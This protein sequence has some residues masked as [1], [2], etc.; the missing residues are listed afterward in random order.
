MLKARRLVAEQVAEQLYAAEAA[1]DAAI[2][3]TATLTGMMPA[4]RAEAG[5]SA[6][7][8]QEA[9]VEASETTAMLVRARS[10]ICA[11]H[12]ALTLAQKQMG[13]GAVNFGGLIIKPAASGEARH[14]AAVT[15][16]EQAA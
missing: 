7:I 10:S 15:S 9:I 5:L 12:K 11:T 4:I 16:A 3:A 1:I 14:L 8:G 6:F 13:L 2:A